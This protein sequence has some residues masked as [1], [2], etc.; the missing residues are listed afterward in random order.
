M[1]GENQEKFTFKSHMSQFD[2]VDKLTFYTFVV[3][4]VAWYFAYANGMGLMDFLWASAVPM[5]LIGFAASR[6]WSALLRLGPSA[7]V[8]E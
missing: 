5:V 4:F 7:P 8:D 3:G 1:S 6:R 2:R